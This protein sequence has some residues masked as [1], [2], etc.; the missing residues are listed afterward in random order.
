VSD[1]GLVAAAMRFKL[2]AVAPHTPISPIIMKHTQ[3]ML[4]TDHHFW[5]GS[6]CC[7]FLYCSGLAGWW[8]SYSRV[9]TPTWALH[10]LSSHCLRSVVVLAAAVSA[11]VVVSALT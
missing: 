11:A 8:A 3:L 2:G 5:L 10:H 9:W 4:P 7:A 1:V 6:H